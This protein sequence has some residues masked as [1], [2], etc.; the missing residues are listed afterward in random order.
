MK[1]TPT[2]AEWGKYARWSHRFKTLGIAIPK[3]G[4][5]SDTLERMEREHPELTTIPDKAL[6]MKRAK[7]ERVEKA[8][9]PEEIEEEE[10]PKE[11]EI[12]EEEEILE[13]KLITKVDTQTHERDITVVLRLKVRVDVEVEE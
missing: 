11:E 3:E 7:K 10:T 13:E 2:Q 1:T 5:L 6:E 12:P 4:H 8:E 9:D